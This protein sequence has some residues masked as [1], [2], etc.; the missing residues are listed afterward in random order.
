MSLL[1]L[2]K[3]IHVISMME[4]PNLNDVENI[5]TDVNVDSEM[6]D[7]PDATAANILVQRTVRSIPI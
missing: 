7:D 5:V 4:V 6:I 3:N 2:D 1:S